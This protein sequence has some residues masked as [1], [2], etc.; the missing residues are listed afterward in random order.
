[1]QFRGT[2]LQTCRPIFHG[3]S[4]LHFNGAFTRL[5]LP[6]RLSKGI[7]Y[8]KRRNFT[9]TLR[10]SSFLLLLAIYIILHFTGLRLLSWEILFFLSL[11]DDNTTLVWWWLLD[12]RML[13][14][15]LVVM[16]D[17]LVSLI[18]SKLMTTPKHWRWFL[19]RYIF[20][21]SDLSSRYY[22]LFVM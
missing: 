12:G 2:K 21:Y 10:I 4:T 22:H 1:M 18:G 8:N 15:T 3:E 20:N 5:P 14:K 9:F 6:I 16:L 11:A 13:C 7:F 17:L 19:L